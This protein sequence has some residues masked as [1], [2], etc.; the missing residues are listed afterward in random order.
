MWAY[1]VKKYENV[2]LMEDDMPFSFKAFY[3]TQ[4]ESEKKHN[5]ELEKV[6]IQ[7]LI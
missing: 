4:K 5:Y 6:S 2:L 7:C 3:Y 1:K